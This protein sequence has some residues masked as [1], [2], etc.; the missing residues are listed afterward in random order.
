MHKGTS[1]THTRTESHY[2][3]VL[4]VTVYIWI[5]CI[6]CRTEESAHTCNHLSILVSSALTRNPNI[7]LSLVPMKTVQSEGRGLFRETRTLFQNRQIAVNSVKSF[8][9]AVSEVRDR[10]LTK[11]ASIRLHSIFIFGDQHCVV[12]LWPILACFRSQLLWHTSE[13]RRRGLTSLF[14]QRAPTS[15]LFRF[16][17]SCSCT[18]GALCSNG[19]TSRSTT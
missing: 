9:N 4:V 1:C 3:E 12:G 15:F 10:Y 16:V 19:S 8:C 13:R 14:Y 2:N 5:E 6:H 17:M 18:E 11:Y 7:G